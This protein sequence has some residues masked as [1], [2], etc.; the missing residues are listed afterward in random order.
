MG[1]QRLLRLMGGLKLS[2][3]TNRPEEIRRVAEE[4]FI[5]HGFDATSMDA[6]ARAADVSK[7]TP[8]IYF[9]SKHDLF[10]AVVLRFLEEIES[11]LNLVWQKYEGV[12][13]VKETYRAYANYAFNNPEKFAATMIFE[14]RDFYPGRVSQMPPNTMACQKVNDRMTTQLFK[15]IETAIAK[16]EIVTDMTAPQFAL[17]TWSA[18][19]GALTIAIER[20]SILPNV[21]GW[22]A[23]EMIETLINHFFVH[24]TK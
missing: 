8:Y 22:T 1:N 3:Q 5:A 10:S 19:A 7:R 2:R 12:A 4:K 18:L 16:G 21:Y 17:M 24:G 14:Q 11:E 23:D 13:A 6:V 15:V 9:K 20:R